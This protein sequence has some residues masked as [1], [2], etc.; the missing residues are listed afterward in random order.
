MEQICME[1]LNQW[2]KYVDYDEN[3]TCFD[4][5]G[6][7]YNTNRTTKKLKHIIEDYDPSGL[8]AVLTAKHLFYDMLTQSKVKLLDAITNVAEL[9]KHKAMYDA[10]NDPEIHTAEIHYVEALKALVQRVIG[11]DLLGDFDN[12][13]FENKVFD[14]TD[15]V[16]NSLDKCKVDVYKR[17]GELS[18]ITHFSAGIHVFPSLAEC[19]L[20]LDNAPDGMYLC[21]IDISHSADSYFGFF[22][23]NNGNLFAIHE[24]VSEPY[25]GQH[26]NSRNGRWTEGKADDIFPY[27]FIFNYGDYDYKG[28]SHTYMIDEDKLM[29]SEA[30]E[31]VYL[32]LL[33]AMMMLSMEF[34]GNALDK[35]N[36]VYIDSLLTVNMPLLGKD[37][38]ALAVITKNELVRSTN[39]VNI[40]F[41]YD[42]IMSGEI[43]DEF[44]SE[45][46]PNGEYSHVQACNAGQL[47]VDLYGEGFQI[48]N[49]IFSTQK[50]LT[51]EEGE[52]IPEF[53]GSEYRFREQAFYEIREQLAD[54]IRQQ[55]LEEYKSYGGM[56]AVR[57]WFVSSVQAS[58]DKIKELSVKHYVDV[59]TGDSK[60]ISAGW[61]PSKC[62]DRYFITTVEDQKYV[63]SLDYGKL[64]LVNKQTKSGHRWIEDVYDDDTG[65]MC[66]MFFVFQF[67]DWQGLE[68]LFGEEVPKI[69]KGWRQKGNRCHGNSIL[70]ITD[71]VEDVGTPF[72]RW[73]SKKEPY[74]HDGTYTNFGFCI[75]F[76]KRGFNALCKKYGYDLKKIRTEQ[77]TRVTED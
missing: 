69:V 7:G 59:L 60:D 47:F 9:E 15:T 49:D 19:V 50:L 13:A 31:D 42:K 34:K 46:T 74:D 52:Y 67:M 40:D 61:L 10:F 8:L 41:D 62:E 5:T 66:T 39:A 2:A 70:S 23:K 54:Y 51:G 57:K 75:G 55:I 18:D 6:W 4:L 64:Y 25:K 58:I 45:N 11:K 1:V 33:I 56:E 27:N 38:T 71:A 30:G 12:E 53:V 43:L 29:L 22:V 65:N 35:Y 20:T 77:A 44:K 14:N 3:Q 37:E 24:R 28:Y 16:I 17:G 76:S 48:K 63:S 32:P 73:E 72:E 26:Q 36:Q 68:N 21:F